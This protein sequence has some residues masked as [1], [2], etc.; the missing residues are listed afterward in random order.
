MLRACRSGYEQPLVRGERLPAHEGE[1][2]TR[3]CRRANVGERGDRIV[4][5]HDSE[6]RD[7]RVERAVVERVRLRVGLVERG[8]DES[9]R[10]GILACTSEQ[11]S[12]QI[13]AS[14][15][16][17][18]D[19]A[20][21]GDGRGTA[22]A[23]DV[24]NR[25]ARGE[26][27][28]FDEHVDEGLE[29]LVVLGLLVDPLPDLVA[30]VPVLGLLPV[31]RAH[32]FLHEVTLPSASV[33]APTRMLSSNAL[34]WSWSGA[35][36]AWCA[37]AAPSRSASKETT[38]CNSKTR[39]R[40]SSASTSLVRSPLDSGSHTRST[41]WSAIVSASV[42]RWVRRW[43][44]RSSMSFIRTPIAVASATRASRAG[45]RTR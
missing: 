18:C 38:P 28:A 2:G 10:L 41:I 24:E 1:T 39:P 33:T 22:A 32:V 43:S 30:V 26:L 9:C 35:L 5:E 19:H 45:L 44:T 37:R 29:H 42:P 4:E 15:R 21:G 12:R 16:A 25:V 27:R 17:G 31:G 13:D 7:H 34:S 8:V 20:R 36:L 14:D 11:G 3:P 6:S 40:R 23:A